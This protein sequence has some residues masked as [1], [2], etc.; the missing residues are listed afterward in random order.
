MGFSSVP[1][2]AARLL[3]V[4]LALAATLVIFGLFLSSAGVD[5]LQ[6]YG[7][8]WRGAFGTWFS[9]QNT[10]VN[11]SPLLLTGLC[12]ALPAQIGLLVIGGL[13]AVAIGLALS[14]AGLSPV[15]IQFA[16]AAAGAA[17]GG[18][19]IALSGLLRIRRG[20]NETISSLLIAYISIAVMEQIV[21]G[22][23]RDP[24]S[25]NRPATQSLAPDVMLG[26][27]PGS[28]I[29]IGLFFGL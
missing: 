25:L 27:I 4:L 2:V 14:S 18:G 19:V 3:P 16:M 11:A 1:Q 10:L 24:A 20:V 21:E 23:M 5:A 22:P 26:T 6:A 13:A 28:T 29:H 15:L 12:T 7:L 9:W 17:A 8:I